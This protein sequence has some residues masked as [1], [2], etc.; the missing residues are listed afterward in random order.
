M[1]KQDRVDRA[2][3]G[4]TAAAE[5]MTDDER[6]QRAIGAALARWGKKHKPK[7]RRAGKRKR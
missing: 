7:G 4:G 2:S 5:A 6:R 3:K 1:N